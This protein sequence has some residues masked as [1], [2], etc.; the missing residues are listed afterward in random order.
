[1]ERAFERNICVSHARNLFH[2]L[3]DVVI[4]KSCMRIRSKSNIAGIE[5]A[6]TCK[7]E[8]RNPT[9]AAMSEVQ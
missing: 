2:R 1:M 7:G 6:Q 5:D 4:A 8:I 3:A 9:Q